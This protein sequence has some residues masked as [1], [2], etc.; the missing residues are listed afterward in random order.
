MTQSFPRARLT[1]LLGM[2]ESDHDG[3]IV[4]AGRLAARLVR[5]AGLTWNDVLAA[6]PTLSTSPSTEKDPQSPLD[7]RQIVIECLAM[8]DPKEADFL[9]NIAKRTH[10]PTPKQVAWL[11]GIAARVLGL[12]TARCGDDVRAG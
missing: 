4:N 1:A 5:S 11:E 8:A 10:P 2:L 6:A 3:E 7:W 9:T 12:T